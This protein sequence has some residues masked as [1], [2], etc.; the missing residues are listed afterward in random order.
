MLVQCLFDRCL[1]LW[2]LCCYCVIL[3]FVLGHVWVCFALLDFGVFGFAFA[4]WVTL[5]CVCSCVMLSFACLGFTVWIV[6][7]VVIL[8]FVL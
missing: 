7:M 6:L 5:L 8:R 3:L 2:V 4:D 1:I